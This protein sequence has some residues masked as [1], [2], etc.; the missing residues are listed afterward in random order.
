[1]KRVKIRIRAERRGRSSV[2]ACRTSMLVRNRATHFFR[3]TDNQSEETQHF[4]KK[5]DKKTGS[6]ESQDPKTAFSGPTTE[7]N[8]CHD[9]MKQEKSV[10]N[11]F[12][13]RA[14]FSED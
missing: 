9:H 6:T 12:G 13:K 4:Q 7:K 1:M 8:E 14:G 2:V 11:T 3:A 5:G 10:I